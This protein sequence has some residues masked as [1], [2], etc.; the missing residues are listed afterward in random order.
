MKWTLKA[1]IAS[2]ENW[3]RDLAATTKSISFMLFNVFL[4]HYIIHLIFTSKLHLFTTC[5][6]LSEIR[7]ND[8]RF[9]EFEKKLS[10]FNKRAKKLMDDGKQKKQFSSKIQKVCSLPILAQN[11]PNLAQVFPSISCFIFCWLQMAQLL[12]GSV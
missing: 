7:R 1:L 3:P 12:K 11:V 2:I 4:S 5:L 8:V 6:Q 9:R 10:D